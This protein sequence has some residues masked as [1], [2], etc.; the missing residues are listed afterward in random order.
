MQVSKLMFSPSISDQDRQMEP[1]KIDLSIIIVNWNTCELLAQCLTSLERA[2]PKL[3][4]EIIVVDNGSADGSVTMVRTRFPQVRLIENDHNAG[5]ARA[6]NQGLSISKARYSLLLNSDTI[7]HPH[8]LERLVEVAESHPSVGVVG[9][10]LLNLDGTLQASWAKY[11][12][13]WSELLG[14]NV[15][16]RRLVETEPDV[17]DVDWIGGACFL[18]RASAIAQVGLLDEDY[19][20][21]S[22]ELDWCFRMRRS[23][24]R[25]FYLASS[26]ITHLGGASASRASSLQMARLYDS[27]IRFFQK[28]YGTASARM[29]R[30]G[31]AVANLAGLVRR[32]VLHPIVRTENLAQRIRSQWGVVLFLLRI[33]SHIAA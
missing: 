26:A 32:I 16:E 23:G 17:Y 15:R 7:V 21:Y 28:H 8:T 12:T 13:L 2:S 1:E 9:C 31:L 5:F 3:R 30:Y 11:P 25:V 24:W 19:F 4:Y 22:E 14:R 33:R 6:N 18:V 10:K 20:M 29:L 27:K